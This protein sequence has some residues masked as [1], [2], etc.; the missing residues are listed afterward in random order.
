MRAPAGSGSAGQQLSASALSGTVAGALLRFELLPIAVVKSCDG[1]VGP[2]LCANSQRPTHRPETPAI[3]CR[4]EVHVTPKQPAEES[5]IFV[6]DLV[7]DSLDRFAPGLE[8]LLGF[9]EPQR[10]HVFERRHTGRQ[11]KAPLE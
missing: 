2:A 7:G 1:N 5:S 6:A 11:L 10:M 3:L 8:H 9:L 4:C